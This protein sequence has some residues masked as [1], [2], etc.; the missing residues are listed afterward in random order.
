MQINV[1][2]LPQWAPFTTQDHKCPHS[3][4]Q[5]ILLKKIG[6]AWSSSEGEN[7]GM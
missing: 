2:N 4:P 7:T 6:M 3:G 5:M 1:G